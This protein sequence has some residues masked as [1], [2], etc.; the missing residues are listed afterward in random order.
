MM[1]YGSTILSF[2]FVLG[3]L[4]FVH[5]LGHFL[6][7]KKCGMR[8]EEFSLGYPPKAFGITFGETEYM[9]SWLPLGGYVKIAGM[10]DFGQDNPEG[11]PWE[12]WSKPRWMQA[13]VMA[14]GPAMNIL[15]GFLLIL[16]VRVG[17]GDEAYLTRTTIGGVEPESALYEAGLRTGDDVVEING[18]P[19]G[20]WRG[21]VGGFSTALG[22]RS[23]IVVDRVGEQVVIDVQLPADPTAIGIA[24]PIKARVGQLNGGYP[25]EG[26][27]LA[28]GDLIT[29]IDGQPV[30][31]W[32]EM[33][34]IIQVSADKA[35][36]VEWVR[37][38]GER[39]SATITPQ[40]DTYDGKVIGMIGIGQFPERVRVSFVRA[41]TRSF[42]DLKAN[43]F[44][45]FGFI[46]RLVSGRGSGAE[47]AGPVQI[48]QFAG[49]SAAAG[50]E[51]LFS[52]M[53]L[54]SVNLAVLNLLPIP[55]LDGGHLFIM[56]IE[57]VTRREMAPKHKEVLQQ[58]GFVFLLALMIYVTANDI[59][60][61]WGN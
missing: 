35:L 11:K 33:S 56:G 24:R 22:T 49:K 6:V 41:V 19:V 27:G 60:R 13:S 50:I 5:E 9:I 4:V 52:F 45:I 29:A 10:S 25:A 31:T 26:S 36:L 28:Y 23:R 46:Q 3:V 53:A 59:G 42:E 40:G 16:F 44:A 48:A 38:D 32:W 34:K 21:V 17:Y 47:L 18:K 30:N 2:I 57:A 43:T 39:M 55:M 20:D 58:I 37:P 14:A 1:S 61:W 8:V 7:A 15:L 51:A 54:L 12:I